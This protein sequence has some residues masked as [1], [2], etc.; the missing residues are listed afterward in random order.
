[1]II[2]CNQIKILSATD[3]CQGF[4]FGIYTIDETCLLFTAGT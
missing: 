1:M 4:L 3:V 2:V